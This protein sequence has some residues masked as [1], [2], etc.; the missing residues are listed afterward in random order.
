MAHYTQTLK[1]PCQF[2]RAIGPHVGLILTTKFIGMVLAHF[3][4]VKQKVAI[5]L[6]SWNGGEKGVKKR[7]EGRMEKEMHVSS[8]ESVVKLD[9][10]L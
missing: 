2:L 9:H 10:V 4:V 8:Q 6:S 5:S 1:V 7:K 3:S